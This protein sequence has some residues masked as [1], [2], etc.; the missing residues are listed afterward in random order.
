V[1]ART[2]FAAAAG[3][4]A[5]TIASRVV[6][7]GR[8]AVLSHAVGTSC[9]GDTYQA[10]NSIPNVVFEVV[11]GGALASLVVPVLAG[12]VAAG[13]RDTANRTASALLT[14]TLVVLTPVALLGMLFAPLLMR[15]L[16]GADPACGQAMDDVGARMLVVFM[17][18]VVLYGVGIV[19]A[20]I[21]QAHHRFLGPAL[22]PL[23]SSIVVIAAY[24]GYAAQ[25]A[26]GL[27][28]LSRT[29]ELT[30]SVGT[31]LGVAVLSLGLVLPVRR[32]GVRLRP[33]LHFPP[34]VARKVRGLAVAGIVGLVAQQVALVVAL[35]L[36]AQG[37]EGAVVVFQVATA[38]F[39]LP[40]AV[41]AVPVATTA[42]PRLTASAESGEEG[43]Y[44]DVAAR[45]LNAVLIAMLGGMA[46]LI[47]VAQPAARLLVAGVPG[48][49]NVTTLADGVVAFA[50]GLVGY[51]VLALVGR[52]LYARG[53]G[54]TV[55]VATVAGWLVVAV[56][57]VLLVATTDVDRVT[58]LGIGNTGGMSVAG[59]LLLVGIRR[60]SPGAVGGFG[61]TALVGAVA[62]TA[63]ILAAAVLPDR[64]TSALASAL[65]GLLLA[66]VC[67]AVFLIVVRVLRPEALRV[68]RHV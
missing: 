33:S 6:G 62:A 68:L 13:D 40:W 3:V 65:T 28:S 53:A 52:A 10:A 50:P 37:T 49:E 19:F 66:V 47:A 29:Q 22:A 4:A 9:V 63:G 57:D 46:V 59:V 8:V 36:A 44:A 14:W 30:L 38:V 5:V 20:G 34:G 2:L 21:V 17:P 25:G 55:A 51:G 27:N 11:A 31:T 12:A 61:P 56:L 41:L 43:T 24:L 1:R 58:A 35:R 48:P 67:G 64:G 60:V 42:F 23:L 26:T 15:A 54:T 7:F 16:V 39:L 18:Q 45:S 32:C